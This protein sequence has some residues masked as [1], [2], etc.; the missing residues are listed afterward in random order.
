MFYL[1]AILLGLI[2]LAWVV[3]AIRTTLGMFALPRIAGARLLPDP[4][5]PSVSILVAGR[6]EA[7][8]ISQALTTWV[9]Q[10]YPRYEVIAV[11]DRSTDATPQILDEAAR[12]HSNLK[13]IHLTELPKG[14]LGKPHGLQ[15]AYEHSTGEWL[16][17]T[18]ADVRFAPDLLRR[19]LAVARDKSWDH[20]T[21]LGG[22]EMEG[23]WEKTVISYFALGFTLRV[24]P[25]EVGNPRSRCY[26]GVG[27]FQLLR[28]SAYESIGTHRRL[29]LE[30]VDDMKLGKLVKAGGFRS[31]VA[32]GDD[33]LYVRWQEGL[34]NLIR[35]LTKNGFAATGFSVSHV[36]GSVLAALALSVLPFLA[37]GAGTGLP[38]LLAGTAVIAA[39]ARHA[40]ATHALRISPLYAFTHPLGAILSSYML[41]RSMVVTL[42]RGGVVWRDTF[43]PLEELKRGQV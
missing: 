37:L 16:V 23:F 26:C 7:A 36:I 21:L 8:K 5:C 11:D 3:G 2:A 42:W 30:V 40:V 34:G 41:L 15:T 4:D 10:D 24:Q 27:A 19:A 38:R 6:D 13:V 20:L 25:W 33:K 12:R 43:Y 18:D 31:G 29:A 14:W 32:L 17:F 1:W 9:G 22:L 35:G 39:L 28:R